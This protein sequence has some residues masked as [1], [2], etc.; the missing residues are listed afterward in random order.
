MRTFGG[1]FLLAT[2]LLLQ[3]CTLWSEHPAKTW[4][5]ATGGE[6]LE[7]NFWRELKAKNW[8]E[9]ERHIRGRGIYLGWHYP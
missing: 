5:D 6:G 2:T 3:A 4:A 7:R 9:L 8:P 1:V